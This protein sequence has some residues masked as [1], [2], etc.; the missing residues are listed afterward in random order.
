VAQ[1][2]TQSAQVIASENNANA[3]TVQNLQ[4]ASS[5]AN[6]VQNGAINAE[7]Q[8]MTNDNKTLLQTS[9]GAA[10][11]YNQ[12]LTSLSAIITNPNLSTGQQ[13]AALNDGMATLSS[14]LAALNAIAA[15]TQAAENLTFS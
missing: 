13:D 12:Q 6:I 15:N 10:Q 11:L 8:Q 5:M 2:Q 9:S 14:G 1:Q 4:N 3:V 7:I